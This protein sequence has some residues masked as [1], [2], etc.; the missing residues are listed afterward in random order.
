MTGR[1]LR[2]DWRLDWRPDRRRDRRLDWW[3]VP[4][5][6]VLVPSAG[7]AHAY[8]VRST[9]ARRAA[10]ITPP[11]RVQLWFNERLEPRFS[12]VSV[13][14]AQGKQVDVG[15][16]QVGPDEPRTLS[17][18]VSLPGPGTYVVRYR[19]LSVDGHVVESSFPFTVRPRP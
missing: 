11:E 12:R 6:L 5:L 13:W 3:L 4:L 19:V 18:G 17:V 7:L 10:L 1:I 15:D 14:D 2:L 16:V 9:P 8:L